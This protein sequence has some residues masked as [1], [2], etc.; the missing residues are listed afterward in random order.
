MAAQTPG[1]GVTHHSL[2]TTHPESFSYFEPATNPT[3]ELSNVRLAMLGNHQAANAAAAIAAI[4]QLR[5]RGWSISDEAIRQGLLTARVPARIE[6][7]QSSPAVILDVAHNLAS[8][9]A[10]LAVLRESFSPRR[11][12]AIFASS[13]DK[14][15][16][17]MLKPHPARL[18]HRFSHPVHQ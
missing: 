12:I 17:G 9:E 2:R 3:Y 10:L 4:H 16:T 15:Y 8:L 11:R 1:E 6:Q 5:A 13:K 14:D 18:R 7:I